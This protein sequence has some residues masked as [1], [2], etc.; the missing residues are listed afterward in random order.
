MT[1][2]LTVV[3]CLL[4]TRRDSVYDYM[5]FLFL[6]TALGYAT[7]MKMCTKKKCRSETKLWQNSA[8]NSIKMESHVGIV[9]FLHGFL[10]LRNQRAIHSLTS[11]FQVPTVTK[12]VTLLTFNKELPVWQ[13]PC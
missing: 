6:T 9:H 7:N 3:C 2:V 13:V 8:Q 4:V 5:K 12:L 11:I 1:E 10:R